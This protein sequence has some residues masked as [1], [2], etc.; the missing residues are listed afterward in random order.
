MQ[1]SSFDELTHAQFNATISNIP[2]APAMHATPAI[3]LSLSILPVK[4]TKKR[5]PPDRATLFF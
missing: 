4:I 5:E 2:T 3:F 1:L